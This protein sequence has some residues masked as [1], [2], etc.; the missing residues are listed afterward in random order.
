MKTIIPNE[1]SFNFDLNDLPAR[2]TQIS[3]EALSLSG[4]CVRQIRGNGGKGPRTRVGSFP[5]DKAAAIC[6]SGGCNLFIPAVQLNGG[7]RYYNCDC[8]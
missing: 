7:V 1:L 4:G 5:A 3:P 6:N 8:C 2:A